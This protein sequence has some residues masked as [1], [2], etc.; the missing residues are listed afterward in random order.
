MVKDDGGRAKVWDSGKL[1]TL[2]IRE[3][4]TITAEAGQDGL[5]KQIGSEAQPRDTVEAATEA[6]EKVETDTRVPSGQCGQLYVMTDF[7]CRLKALK[8]CSK[9]LWLVHW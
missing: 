9:M 8:I 7:R 5:Q 4:E 2:T 6:G 1:S 3:E